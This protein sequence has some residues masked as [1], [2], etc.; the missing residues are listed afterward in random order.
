MGRKIMYSY[1]MYIPNGTVISFRR[2][3]DGTLYFSIKD[4]IQVSVQHK[5]IEN[6]INRILNNEFN[7]CFYVRNNLPE[8][9]NCREDFEV[10]ENENYI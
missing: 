3:V 10:I 7:R 1:L 8:Y 6:F 5:N 4:I 2:H 9:G